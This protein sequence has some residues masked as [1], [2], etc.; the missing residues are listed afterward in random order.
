MKVVTAEEMQKIDRITIEE[1]GIPGEVLMGYAG[2]S[3]ADFIHKNLKDVNKIAVFSGT[4]N[5][6][7]D[8]FVIAYLIYNTG[9]CVDIFLTGKIEKISETSKIYYDICKNS[10]ISIIETDE[11][12]SRINI[13]KYCLIV[14]AMLGTGFKG[15]PRGPV[16]KA[17]EKINERN[18]RSTR[19][20]SVDLPSGLPSDGEA[21]LGA[22]VNADYTVTIGLPKLSCVT[23]PGKKYIGELIITDIGFPVSLTESEDL[24]VELMDHDYA[25]S[26]F[27]NKE[28]IDTHKGIKGH[29]L[30]IGGFDNMEGAIILTAKAAFETGVG[31]ATL[32]TT[33][34]ARK[35]IAGKIPELIT[36]SIDSSVFEVNPDRKKIEQNIEN[37]LDTFF[38]KRKKF[39]ALVIG[40][41]MGR[42]DLSMILFNKIMDKL[43]K[44][45]IHRLL[46]DGDG[47]FYLADYLKNNTLPK[48]VSVVITPHFLEASRF[49]NKAVEK[50][51][52][53]RVQSAVELSQLTGAVALLKGPSTII[54][55]GDKTLINSSGNPALATAGSGDVLSGIIGA[56]LLKD[57]SPINSAGLGAYIH[58]L[59]ADCYQEN[60]KTPG[61]KAGDI[62]KNI[63]DAVKSI[64]IVSD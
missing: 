64:S 46:V 24:G 5:N 15:T 29:L 8:G 43:E 61:M 21:P 53:N 31:L 50:I 22:V 12:L 9:Y 4:G 18:Y 20:L 44:Y 35:I 37:D 14:D 40:P 33:P 49:T 63:R 6:G 42:N 39:D 1:L 32:L 58:G 45:N 27:N 41:G 34:N 36:A 11:D 10:G 47:L 30:I 13:D 59:A 54:T 3:I 48:K 16:H 7:G 62:I 28:D 56:L 57:L 17:I 55:R 26:I 38:S 51:K 2:K 25:Q 19:L 52:D 60:H 23:W